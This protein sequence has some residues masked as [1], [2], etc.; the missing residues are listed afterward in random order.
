[1]QSRN[2]IVSFETQRCRRSPVSLWSMTCTCSPKV[3]NVCGS[4]T[5]LLPSFP[6]HHMVHGVSTGGQAISKALAGLIAGL[7]SSAPVCLT[8]V[9]QQGRLCRA[10]G[11]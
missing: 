5:S 7:H 1:M 9:E 10:V 2:C 8:H 4:I 3:V 11:M 6:N